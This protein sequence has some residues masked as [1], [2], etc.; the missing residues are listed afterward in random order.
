MDRFTDIVIRLRWLII[1]GFVG[2]TAFFA[3]R[4]PHAE[5]ESSIKEH[6][7]GRFVRMT[8]RGVLVQLSSINLQAESSACSI[9]V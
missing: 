3:S 2:F 7:L 8:S 9:P 1:F 6:R 4:A 5:V